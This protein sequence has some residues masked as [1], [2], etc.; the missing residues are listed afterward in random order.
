MTQATTPPAQ[1]AVAHAKYLRIT[2]RKMR[3]VVDAIRGKNIKEAE[4]LLR[5]IPRGAAVP[6]AKVLKSAKANATNNY[7]MLEDQLFVA[8]AYVNEGPTLKR[9]LPRARGRGDYMMKRTSHL[10]II[11]EE[12]P[13]PRRRPVAAK[14]S[15]AAVEAKPKRAPKAATKVSA[16]PK[17]VKETTD[18][19]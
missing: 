10:T 6:I 17:A 19:Q 15:D 1:Q 11:L 2:P 4:D 12:K 3:L 16:E 14:K 18:G 5:F 9:I 13:A 7:D 8:S